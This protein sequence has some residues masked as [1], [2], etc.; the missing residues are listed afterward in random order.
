MELEDGFVQD[1]SMTVMCP[2]WWMRHDKIVGL[3]I[4]DDKDWLLDHQ[5][6]GKPIRRGVLH[7]DSSAS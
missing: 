3:R 1:A 2:V 6:D 5:H 7:S 4:T